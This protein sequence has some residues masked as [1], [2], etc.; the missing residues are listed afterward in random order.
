MDE[1]GGVGVA[2]LA[3]SYGT[4]VFITDSD[5]EAVLPRTPERCWFVN[6]PPPSYGTRGLLW[7]ALPHAEAR[8]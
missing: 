7:L 2:M 8:G 4:P 1:I 6:I 5:F 3:G